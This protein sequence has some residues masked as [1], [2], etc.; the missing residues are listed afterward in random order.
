MAISLGDIL[1]ALQNGAVA[2][3]G[4]SRQVATTFPQ[5]GAFSTAPSA[6]VGVVTFTSSQT[7]GFIPVTT[8]SGFTGYV[9]LYPSS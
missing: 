9:P 7:I 1:S 6:A 3:N 4:L 8:S 5:R 2:V